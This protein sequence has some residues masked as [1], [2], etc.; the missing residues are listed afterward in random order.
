MADLKDLE[1]KTIKNIT[2]LQKDS[3]EVHIYTECGAQY[4]FWHCQD[5]CESVSLNDFEGNSDSLVGGFISLAEEVNGI[6]PDGWHGESVTWTFYKID[7]TKGS[8]WLR[9]LGASNGYYS[10]GV[11]FTRVDDGKDNQ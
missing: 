8:L 5:C 1:G 9:W 6:A 4:K 7:T 2:G 11:D 3:E 10:E